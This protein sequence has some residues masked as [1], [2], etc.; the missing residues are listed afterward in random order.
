MLNPAVQTI[1]RKHCDPMQGLVSHKGPTIFYLNVQIMNVFSFSRSWLKIFTAT[2]FWARTDS[3]YLYYFYMLYN[4]HMLSRTTNR[5][6]DNASFIAHRWRIKSKG[7]HMNEND[8]RYLKNQIFEFEHPSEK[9][10]SKL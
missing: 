8:C 1:E 3:R 7:V 10:L 5:S 2:I 4:L 9:L 6:K